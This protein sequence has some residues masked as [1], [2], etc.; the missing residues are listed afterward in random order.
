MSHGRASICWCASAMLNEELRGLMSLRGKKK[1]VRSKESLQRSKFNLQRSMLNLA[2]SKDLLLGGLL[3]KQRG[4][5]TNLR[6]C[7]I[8]RAAKRLCC[9]AFSFRAARDRKAA[10]QGGFAAQQ[11]DFAT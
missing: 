10:Q 2:C 7:L 6:G 9:T 3:E 8:P 5:E 1:K 11:I 4:L